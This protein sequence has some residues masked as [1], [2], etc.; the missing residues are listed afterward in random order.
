MIDRFEGI[1]HEWLHCSIFFGKPPF[2]NKKTVFPPPEKG[3]RGW[4]WEKRNRSCFLLAHF[5]MFSTSNKCLPHYKKD[6]CSKDK[7]NVSMKKM[8]HRL[9]NAPAKRCWSPKVG[10][11]PILQNDIVLLKYNIYLQT[12]CPTTIWV[13]TG[14]LDYYRILGKPDTWNT[15]C[16]INL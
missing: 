8:P 16:V 9:Y 11:Q 14:A 6:V 7:E 12:T 4:K 13:F 1:L 10:A 5:A 15:H 3:N 2:C